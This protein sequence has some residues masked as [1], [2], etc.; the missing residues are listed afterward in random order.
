MTGTA[1]LHE[2]W[3][4]SWSD[5]RPDNPLGASM[6]GAQIARLVASRRGRPARDNKFVL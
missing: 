1:D 4:N 6:T 3:L 5:T 2:S